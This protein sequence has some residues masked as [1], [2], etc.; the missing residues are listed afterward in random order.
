MKKLFVIFAVILLLSPF[1][2]AAQTNPCTSAGNGGDLGKCVSQIY[3]WSI[4]VSGLLAVVMCIFGGY[5]VMS[6][7]GNGQQAANGK[8]YI[9][10]SLIGMVLLLGAYLILNTINPDLVNFNVN[11]P[12]LPANTQQQQGSQNTNTQQQNQQNNNN[13]SAPVNNIVPTGP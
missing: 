12:A 2:V 8:T 7:R 11:L 6:A 1:I 4:G 13:Q 10:S 9:V 5:L 3:V